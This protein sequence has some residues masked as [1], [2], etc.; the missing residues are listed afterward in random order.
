[1]AAALR[2][3][4]PVGGRCLGSDFAGKRSEP[5]WDEIDVARASLHS[6][7]TRDA[8]SKSSTLMSDGVATLQTGV[9]WRAADA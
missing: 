7:T 3:F 6:G 5:Q 1:M 8:L 2:I 9:S 4:R